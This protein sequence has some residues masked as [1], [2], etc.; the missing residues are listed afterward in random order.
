MTLNFYL[1]LILSTEMGK[2]TTK[3]LRNNKQHQ[4]VGKNYNC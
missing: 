4:R 1:M 2:K 3:L